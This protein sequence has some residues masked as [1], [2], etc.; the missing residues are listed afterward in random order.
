MKVPASAW[1]RLVDYLFQHRLL[2]VVS[3]GGSQWR[4]PWFTS[5]RWDDETQAWRAHVRPGFVN[6]QDVTVSVIIE[7]ERRDV[8]L[9]EDPTFPLS[10]FR[11]LGSDTISIDGSGESVPEFFQRLGVR[12]PRQISTEIG[13]GLVETITGLPEDAAEALP[14]RQLR[15]CDLVL[16]CLRP[17]TAVEWLITPAETGA[18]AQL[19]LLTTGSSA[20]QASLRI[21]SRYQPIQAAADLTRLEG[22]VTDPGFDEAHVATVYLLS[23]ESAGPESEID[24]TWT[25][26]VEHHLF[27]NADYL[28]TQPTI[29]PRQNLELNLAG[30]GGI[31]G[32]QFTVNQLLSLQNDATNNALTFLLGNEVTGRI[33]TPGHSKGS[34]KWDKAESL[35]PPF[36]FFGIG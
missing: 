17:R 1:N 30:L 3:L 12:A 6:G 22:L 20:H 13:D 27:W 4:H 21:T 15:A 35:D 31:A 29:I 26:Y 34:I 7:E 5:V 14:P 11:A 23:P 36:P 33:S 32:A 24:A 19:T 8:P 9:T 18:Q 10:S 16:R 28:T 25:P 2:S